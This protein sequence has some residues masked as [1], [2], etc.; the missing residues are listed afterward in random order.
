MQNPV[1]EKYGN[2]EIPIHTT[3]GNIINVIGEDQVQTVI[4][5]SAAKANYKKEYEHSRNNIL[6][7]WFHLI[8]FI[9]AFSC[10]SVITLEFIDK[11]KR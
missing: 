5:E 4:E 10:L 1:L 7:N 9:F 2:S 11:D 3:L 8:L 6:V